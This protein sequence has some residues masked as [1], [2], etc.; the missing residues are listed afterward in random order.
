[1]KTLISSV[2]LEALALN[3][4][5]VALVEDDMRHGFSDIIVGF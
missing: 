5:A 1:M 2:T 3:A 4:M